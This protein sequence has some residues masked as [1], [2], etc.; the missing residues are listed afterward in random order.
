MAYTVIGYIRVSSEEQAASG[1]SLESQRERIRAYC[2]ARG[3]ELAEIV[4]DAG[5]SAR[6]LERPGM[7]S[8]LRLVRERLVD[9]VVAV[10]LDRLTR[11]VRDLHE[12]LR[13]SAEHGVGMVSVTENMDTASAAGRLMLTMLGAMAEWER[14]V[15]SERTVAALAVKRA[16]GERISRYAMIGH[17]NGTRG[18]HEREALEAIR[19]MLTASDAL[20]LRSM[21]SQLAARGLVN[22]AGK[23][24]HASAVS[25]MV[26]RIVQESPHLERARPTMATEDRAARI[27]AALEGVAA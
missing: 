18:E 2:H 5:W 24:Y 11:S 1:L 14:E 19:E 3:W 9:A 4:T 26:S 10:K 8:V 13:L 21:A 15:I 12:L 16:R 7:D 25:R 27:V 17:E 20:S 22:R 23:P 6:T